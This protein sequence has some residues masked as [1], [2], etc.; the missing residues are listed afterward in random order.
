MPWVNCLCARKKMIA[1]RM[2]AMV[3]VADAHQAH[4]QLVAEV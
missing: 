4:V 3:A 1:G 2:T